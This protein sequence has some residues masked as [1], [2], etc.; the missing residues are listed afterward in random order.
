MAMTTAACFTAPVATAKRSSAPRARAAAPRVCAVRSAGRNVARTFGVK[1]ASLTMSARATKSVTKCM[2]GGVTPDKYPKFFK[3]LQESFPGAMPYEEYLVATKTMLATKGYT[4]DNSLALIS[5]CRDEITRP[6]VDAADQ[7]WGHSF[8][9]ASLAG[10]VMCGKTG[11]AAGLSHAPQQDLG[12][13]GLEKYVFI[14]GPHIAVSADGEVGKVKRL[15]R[16]AMSGAC[17]AVM[18]FQGE[19]AGGT[20]TTAS[21]EVDLELNLM[22]QRLLTMLKFG[23]AVPNLVDLTKSAHDR[24]IADT[25][26][27]AKLSVNADISCSAYLSGVLIHG[28]EYSHFFWPGSFTFQTPKG[29]TDMS[30]D[31]AG[32]DKEGYQKEMGS[33]IEARNAMNSVKALLQSINN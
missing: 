22:K 12:A 27:T 9:I 33:Y 4:G 28:P 1:P 5:M 7:L 15:G 11:F 24:I 17:G 6:F 20:L 16:E 31:L 30:K 23:E 25:K 32:M 10:M 29:S 2:Q 19:L 14:V 13:D 8:S 21:D 18:A 26:A 3:E